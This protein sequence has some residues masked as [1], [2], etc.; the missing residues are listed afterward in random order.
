MSQKSLKKLQLVCL[1]I[2]KCQKRNLMAGLTAAMKMVYHVLFFNNT[3][4]FVLLRH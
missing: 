2:P 4:K 1:G 3:I